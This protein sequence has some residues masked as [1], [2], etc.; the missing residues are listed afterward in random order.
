MCVNMCT[1][2]VTT[3]YLLLPPF[4]HPL[5]FHAPEGPR[6][7]QFRAP[8][9]QAARP[10]RGAGSQAKDTLET[11]LATASLVERATRLLRV[12]ARCSG[13]LPGSAL[14]LCAALDGASKMAIRSKRKLY[15][16]TEVER[17]FH[18]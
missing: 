18:F 11:R 2:E 13:V 3:Y 14:L 5:P 16:G 17:Y 15:R 8:P 10:F 1:V 6:L 7:L 4:R 12:R 9:G